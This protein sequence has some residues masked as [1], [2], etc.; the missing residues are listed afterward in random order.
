[1]K[2]NDKIDIKYRPVHEKTLD[3]NDMFSMPPKAR[4]Y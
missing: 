2:K 3:E 1:M 4:V